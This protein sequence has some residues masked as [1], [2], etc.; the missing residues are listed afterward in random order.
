MNMKLFTLSI[1]LFYIISCSDNGTEHVKKGLIDPSFGLITENWISQVNKMSMT[2]IWQNEGID[3]EGNNYYFLPVPKSPY[4]CSARFFPTSDYFQSWFGMYTINDNSGG[5]YALSD[6]ELNET[7]ILKLGLAD[8]KAW[9]INFAG[10][11][12]PSVYIDSTTSVTKERIIIDSQSGWKITARLGTNVDVGDNNPTDIPEIALIKKEY[13]ENEIKGYQQVFVDV[14]LF[15]WYAPEN[16]ELNVAYFNG[17]EYLSKDGNTF[18]TP[19]KVYS[20]LE[21]MVDKISVYQ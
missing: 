6:D 9:L 2:S 16:K 15:V 21:K 14:F 10:L 4:P 11:D 1:L 12:T 20:E 8:Q 7:E 3:L 19:E 18:K 17:V 13:W 5:T